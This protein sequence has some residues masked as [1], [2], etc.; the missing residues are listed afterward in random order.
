MNPLIPI[1]LGILA[2][3]IWAAPEIPENDEDE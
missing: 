1:I 3:V 2:I